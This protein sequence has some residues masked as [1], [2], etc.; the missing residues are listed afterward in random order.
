[1]T[2]LGHV[3]DIREIGRENV[4][5]M[6]N[7]CVRRRI[8]AVKMSLGVTASQGGS[9]FGRNDGRGT[10]G[11]YSSITQLDGTDPHR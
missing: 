4:S 1:M 5:K 8:K 9:L 2:L 10:Q 7:V 6:L 11:I 3:R